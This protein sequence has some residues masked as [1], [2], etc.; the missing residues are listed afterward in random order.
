MELR[1]AFRSLRRTPSYSLTVIAV[2]ALSMC[3]ATTVFAVVD[4]VLFRGLPFQNASELQL[5]TGPTALSLKDVG[6][7]PAA[8]TDVRMS[9][10]QSTFEIGATVEDRPSR[11]MG[12][13]VG[14]GFFEVLGLRPVLGG[15]RQQH[16]VYT[17]GRVPALISYRIWRQQFG[18]DPNV[19]G[20]PFDLVGAVD[21]MRS[22][23]AGFEIVGVL[24]ADFAFPSMG[25]TPDLVL[26]FAPRPDREADRNSGVMGV[27]ARIPSGRSSEEVR[28]R[29]EVIAATQGFRI[30]SASGN[31]QR[32]R[33]VEMTDIPTLMGFAAGRGFRDAF[34]VAV[35]LVGLACVNIA[36]LGFARARQRNRELAI[37]VA[38]GA[39]FWRI[40]RL[41][42]AE[43]TPLA[44][45]GSGMGFALSPLAI[46]LVLSLM[47]P[48]TQL[49][50]TPGVDG[51]V[52]IFTL[53]TTLLLLMTTVILQARGYRVKALTGAVRPGPTVTW[54]KG[55]WQA[56]LIGGQ[57][58]LASLL[59]VTGTLFVGS[60]WW[61]WQQEPGFE[62]GQGVLVEVTAGTG[63]SA[64]YEARMREV[65]DRV[66]AIPGLRLG[67]LQGEFLNRGRSSA[68]II[69]PQGALP[70][71]REQAL[72]VGGEFFDLLGLKAI[73]G[74][75]PTLEE[76]HSRAPVAIVSEGVARAFWPN[77]EPIG[78]AL[79]PRS[80]TASGWTV[81]G[82]VP[83]SRFNGI[84]V[85][86]AGQIYFPAG[87]VARTLIAVGPTSADV[88][89]RTVSQVIRSVGTPIGVTRAVTLNAA[90][91]ESMRDRTF[92]AWLYG[93]FATAALLIASVG[94]LGLVAM[95]TALRTREIGVRNALGARPVSVLSLI[96]RE[97]IPPILA[98][99]FVGGLAASWTVKSLKS[100][101]F[102]FSVYDMRLWAL[103]VMTVVLAAMLGSLIPAMRAVRTNV[104]H[105]LRAD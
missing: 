61:A 10:Y 46:R 82:V 35:T 79:T 81:I 40:V 29:I 86:P 17:S 15:F 100:S 104:I 76:L 93:G 18:S 65:I 28:S 39:S 105:A 16:F 31:P 42:A 11:L 103:A 55:R 23:L 6:E 70:G 22:P 72:S 53:F 75:L 88:T 62:P 71:G 26:P 12:A 89:V 19:V 34:L 20:R 1:Q 87:P 24:P 45:V 36:A 94:V 47:N 68:G 56:V 80:P 73:Q 66:S 84:D 99:V 98:G 77:G 43:L 13:R 60:L 32:T 38:L 85:Q 58:A 67:I 33:V 30:S 21:H 83:D 52:A 95:T 91:G 54:R 97:Q 49:M 78:Q 37:R 102:Q 59:V 51:R 63:T 44:A 27:L 8:A 96:L 4:G 48:A 90:L 25:A 57:V 2:I 41:G 5:F 9:P 7:W 3:L 50:A 74:R 92:G 101:M 69:R 14:V 64:Q